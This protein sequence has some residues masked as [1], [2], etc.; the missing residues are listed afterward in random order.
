MTVFLFKDRLRH[1]LRGRY[2]IYKCR[3]K[4]LTDI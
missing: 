2:T 3:A 1:G 4:E